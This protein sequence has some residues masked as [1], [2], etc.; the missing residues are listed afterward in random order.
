MVRLDLFG[1]ASVGSGGVGFGGRG[2]VCLDVVRC[3]MLVSSSLFGLEWPGSYG[4][5][6]FGLIEEDLARLWLDRAWR[7]SVGLCLTWFGVVDSGLVGFCRSVSG[8]V[9]CGRLRPGGVLPWRLWEVKSEFTC[10][11]WSLI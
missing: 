10:Q 4:L 7:G 6:W 11:P 5:V 2:V 3:V 1:F 8:V 9:W